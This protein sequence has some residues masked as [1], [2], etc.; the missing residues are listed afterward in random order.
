LKQ[1]GRDDDQMI[2]RFI[3]PV[4]SLQSSA[5]R[6]LFQFILILSASADTHRTP[7]RLT[8]LYLS[9]DPY[10][11]PEPESERQLSR[12][13]R[14]TRKDSSNRRRFSPGAGHVSCGV[15]S[16]TRTCL[17]FHMLRIHQNQFQ[18]RFETGRQSNSERYSSTTAWQQIP[19]FVNL[20][21]Y[22]FKKESPVVLPHCFTTP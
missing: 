10:A 17:V 6:R 2:W 14:W 9:T 13:I 12:Y 3:F 20:Y 5:V 21:F 15:R 22:H 16:W 18:W 19:S 4:I 7:L 8:I 1:P 11:M